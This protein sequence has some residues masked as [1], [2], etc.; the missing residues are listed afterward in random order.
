MRNEIVV[1][2]DDSPS[3]KAALDWAAEQATSVGA[4]LR[5]VHVLD[6]PYGLSSIGFPRPVDMMD[7]SREEL[8]D[9][10][11]QA[12]TE[13][14]EA[15]SPHL[16]WTLHFAS[17][18]TGQVLVQQ[19]KDARLLVVGTREHVGWGRLLS[20]SVS[21]YC[22]SHAACPVVAVPA[23]VSGRR[24]E[25]S[26]IVGP[27]AAVPIDEDED[28]GVAIPAAET[29]IDGTDAAVKTRIVVGVDASA[30]SVAAA[31]YAVMAAERRRAD[32]VLVHAFPPP[33]R[34]SETEAALSKARTT[35]DKLL[36]TVAAQLIVPPEV[37]L[38]MQAEPGDATAVLKRA[39]TG[40]AMLVLGRDHVSWS[41]RLFMGAVAAQ[42]A[43]DV[44]CP[45][46]VVPTAWRTRRAWPRLPVIVA[47]D[48]ETAPEPALKLAFEE[49]RLR[50]ARLIVLHAE[51]MSA[52]ARDLSTAGSDLGLVLTE[53]KQH[54][55]DVAITTMIVSGD[56][57][58]QLV[59]WSRS[60]AV[61]ILGRPHRRRWGSWTR[62]V[63]RSVMK[64][65]HC[66]L[67]VPPQDM[68]ESG[69]HQALAEPALT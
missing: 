63:A 19:S 36:T 49:A 68:A 21:H 34:A 22:L 40:A 4:A 27:K 67:I 56:P 32:V 50:D 62:S 69:Q 1:G 47:L 35:A 26:D 65:T 53:W 8:D 24:A 17:G 57:D 16:D 61:L 42:L 48:R 59:R 52:S 7:V 10:Y 39:A 31:R 64:Q 46:V 51:P 60:A 3:G 6:W 44:A 38:H 45:L 13:V 54:H 37:R 29:T 33:E 23:P 41:E 20:G 25:D 9:S 30:E 55:P 5:A 43:Y 12:I 14:F 2:L 58:A 28:L 15:V 18:D 66:P 11:R